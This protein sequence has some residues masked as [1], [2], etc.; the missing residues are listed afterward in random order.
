[1][2]WDSGCPAGAFV[3]SPDPSSPKC[4]S[5]PRR[6]LLL[7]A[8]HFFT[9]PSQGEGQRAAFTGFQA[10]AE[11]LTGQVP[12][13][14]LFAISDVRESIGLAYHGGEDSSL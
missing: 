1:M 14:V 4:G 7:D 5:H 10:L 11:V 2:V 8:P 6:L 13:L 12:D 3:S 9:I